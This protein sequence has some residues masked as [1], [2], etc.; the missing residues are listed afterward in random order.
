MRD[1]EILVIY[2]KE[3]RSAL[4]ERSIV[5]NSVLLPIFLYPVLL[6]VL[7][8]GITFAE[9]LAEGARSR[10]AVHGLPSEHGEVLDS[11]RSL[12]SLDVVET[13][14][15]VAESDARLA[16]GELDAVAK[17]LSPP[18]A[19]EALPGSFTVRIAYDRSLE[20]SRRARQRVERVVERYRERWLRREAEGMAIPPEDIEGFRVAAQD[21]ATGQQLGALLLSQML[22]LFLVIMVALGCF[23]PAIDTTA[24]ERE[25]STWETTLT[26]AASRFSVVAAK[27]LY[28]ATLGVTAGVLNVVAMFLS[29][30]AVIRPLLSGAGEQFQFSLPLLA[31]PVMVLGVVGLGLFFAA[32][33]MIL[34]AFARTFKEGQGM[35][36]PVY[37][38]A[39]IPLLLG[40]SSETTLT[41]A[42]AAIPIGN[43][44]LMVRDAVRGIFLWPLVAETLAV[45]VVTVV[46]CLLVARAILGFEDFLIGSY[47]GSFWRFLK[48]R[49]LVRRAARA[50]G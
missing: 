31:L 13:P 45:V 26:V 50:R 41:P 42:T 5:L 19:S 47:D 29:M 36:T 20:R 10:V 14:A 48:D 21:V 23:V 6:W 8:T 1:S 17:F 37:W 18:Q 3:L 30:G 24:G 27:Y 32:A 39:L 46:L 43:V 40:Q 35:V 38:L 12:S 28:V 15:S 22:P 34:A 2:R 49:V 9:G 25:R 7:F 4:R 11:L 44:A 33:M 16:R